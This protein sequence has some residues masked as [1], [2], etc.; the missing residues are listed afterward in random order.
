MATLTAA[1]RSEI[2]TKMCLKAISHNADPL[3]ARSNDLNSAF[4]SWYMQYLAEALP[5]S[6]EQIRINLQRGT[7]HG[8]SQYIPQS[9]NQSGGC[10]SYWAWITEEPAATRNFLWALKNDNAWRPLTNGGVCCLS[11][12][13]RQRYQPQK[14]VVITIDLSLIFRAEGAVPTINGFGFK[15]AEMQPRL[16]ED[17]AQV[18]KE[19]QAV[20]E[21]GLR[22]HEELST[23]M[24][25]V[26]TDNQ[27]IDL[28]PEALP[29]LP[30]KE[31]KTKAVIPIEFANSLREKL[32]KGVPSPQKKRG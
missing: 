8:T 27:L 16:V 10:S 11:L 29:F 13:E 3:I 23:L 28:M 5:L 25:A 21:S 1:D 9:R 30:V 19:L 15:I 32:T 7:L 4:W 17:A 6:K 26:R 2:A 24:S 22:F 18:C 14:H 20:I 31:P 12:G